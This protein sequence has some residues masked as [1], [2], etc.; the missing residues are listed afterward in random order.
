MNGEWLEPI[1]ATLGLVL[2]TLVTRAFFMLPERDLPLPDWLRRG[3]K[4]APLAALAAVIAPELVMSQGALI[5][6]LQ[7]AR[8][9]AEL[10]DLCLHG[11][12]LI[13]AR[14]A[15]QH[16]VVTGAGQAQGDGPADAAAGAGHQ[17]GFS[18]CVCS[19]R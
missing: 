8:L 19:C 13:A 15:V 4:Y 10:G 14:A 7:D 18:H 5:Q 3:L 11:F 2:I 12:G 1:L 6:T 17:D 9:P 16:D